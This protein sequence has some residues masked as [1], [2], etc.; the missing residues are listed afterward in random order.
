MEAVNPPVWGWVAA[1]I[2]VLLV[3]GWLGRKRAKYRDDETGFEQA[4]VAVDYNAQTISVKGRTFP[5]TAVRGVRWIKA[6]RGEKFVSEA[7]IELADMKLPR[8]KVTFYANPNGAE[9]FSI[10]LAVAVER[11]G[12]SRII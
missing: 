3:F 5:V 8:H 4:G 6:P 1:G 12:G 11:A 2:L 9:K 10:R 7:I